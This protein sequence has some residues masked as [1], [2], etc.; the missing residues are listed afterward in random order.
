MAVFHFFEAFY[1]LSR[2]HSALGCLSPIEYE[3]KHH[4]LT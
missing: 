4:E 3:S 1:N 2:R